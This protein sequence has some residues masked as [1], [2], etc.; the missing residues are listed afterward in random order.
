[1]A[2]NLFNYIH[3]IYSER[4]WPIL[5]KALDCLRNNLHTMNVRPADLEQ[6]SQ[7][8]KEKVYSNIK[9]I[10]TAKELRAL[11]EYDT[12]II[13]GEQYHNLK[14]LKKWLNMIIDKPSSDLMERIHCRKKILYPTFLSRAKANK[15]LLLLISLIR[16]DYHI[17]LVTTASKSNCMDILEYHNIASL[18]ELILT[19]EDVNNMKPDPEG[20]IKA[21]NYFETTPENTLVFEDSD[22]GIE[23]ARKCGASILTVLDF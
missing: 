15:H 5:E 21:I 16:S 9:K 4:S 10:E 13:N 17:A 20:F 22:S 6:V 1:M 11:L 23:A 18:F 3:Y 14:H 8:I 12:L 19:Q 2:T 7:Y